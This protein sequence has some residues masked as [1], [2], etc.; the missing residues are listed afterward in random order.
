VSREDLLISISPLFREISQW[1]NS[2]GTLCI[3]KIN[4]M[5]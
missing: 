4:I 2:Y 1:V 5:I 3:A